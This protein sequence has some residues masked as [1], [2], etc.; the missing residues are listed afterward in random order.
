MWSLS[1]SEG[2]LSVVNIGDIVLHIHDFSSNK[3]RKLYS[4]GFVTDI[5]DDTVK[6]NCIGELLPCYRYIADVKV[7]RSAVHCARIITPS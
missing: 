3:D 2:Y 7:L 5:K 4:L 6:I 1:V